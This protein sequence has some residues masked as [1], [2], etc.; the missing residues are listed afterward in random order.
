MKN[1]PV[2]D[3]PREKLISLGPES[4][5]N[6]ELLSILISSGNASQSVTEISKGILRKYN[7]EQLSTL[8]T[9]QLKKE[10]GIGSAK[11]CQ[12][13]SSFEMGRRAASFTKEE[14]K[15]N[16]SED[17]I[18]MLAPRMS[19]LAS[20][21]FKCIYLN[22]RHKVLREK[23]LFQGTLNE[24]VV[25]PRE[26]FKIALEENAAAVILVHNHPSGDPTPSEEDIQITKELLKAGN[27]LGIK[28]LDHIIIGK[29]RNW[30]I[31]E[32]GLV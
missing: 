8:N 21:N 7:I 30:S 27:I 4:L 19:N 25:H 28:V 12:I 31:M 11:A 9:S 32:N 14:I 10:F 13:V 24:S 20:E 2:S 5:G 1:T 17:V 26:I 3:R 16:C 29:G 6:S 23:T 22:T 18:R 15:I